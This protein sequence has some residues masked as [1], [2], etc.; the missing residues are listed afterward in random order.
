MLSRMIERIAPRR[1][2]ERTEVDAERESRR[3]ELDRRKRAVARLQHALYAEQSR[4]HFG[5]TIDQAFSEGR[6]A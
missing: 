5:L 3:A 1:T 2:S 4:N 6:K